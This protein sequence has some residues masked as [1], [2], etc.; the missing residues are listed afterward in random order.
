MLVLCIA[1]IFLGVSYNVFALEKIVYTRTRDYN[2]YNHMQPRDHDAPPRNISH[3]RIIPTMSLKHLMEVHISSAATGKPPL[4]IASSN[5]YMVFHRHPQ[6]RKSVQPPG[7][8]VEA[9]LN[10]VLASGERPLNSCVTPSIFEKTKQSSQKTVNTNKCI[11]IHYYNPP[12]WMSQNYF[13]DCY[14]RCYLTSGGQY[15]SAQAVLFHTSSFRRAPPP[16]PPG[17]IWIFHSMESPVYSK[18]D[19][20]KWKRRF[21]WTLTY[22]R[23]SDILEPGA[24][25]HKR[26]PELDVENYM[27][28]LPLSWRNKSRDLAWFVSRCQVHSS[29]GVYVTKMTKFIDIDIFGKCGKWTC[30]TEKW[31][32]CN[33]MLNKLYRFYLSFEN[34]LCVDYRTEKV[35]NLFSD[36]VYSIPVIRDNSNSSMFLPPGS[37][38]DTKNFKTISSLVEF[39]KDLSKN[40]TLSNKYYS[41]WRRFYFQRSGKKSMCELCERVH[42]AEEYQRLYD[43]MDIWWKGSEAQNT[44]M[45]QYARDIK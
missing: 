3:T 33:L 24:E 44:R 13:D 6:K 37:Y 23:D 16:K 26:E 29:R 5:K 41:W 45:C 12:D 40:E 2:A 19:F 7:N 39:M 27:E 32:D 4:F 22:R 43:D 15:E 18:T 38:I 1:I 17:Q 30:P 20:H 8:V 21:N 9:A 14:F 36:M 42:R 10:F 34:A 25:L 35:F 31:K 28:S 11:R